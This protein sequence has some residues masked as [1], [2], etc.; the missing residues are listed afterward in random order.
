MSG[1]I[2]PHR[3]DAGGAKLVFREKFVARWLAH[4][5]RWISEADLEVCAGA[6]PWSSL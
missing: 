6:L 1:R 2:Y 5:R 4:E 3:G